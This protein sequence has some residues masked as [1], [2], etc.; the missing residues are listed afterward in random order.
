M[1]LVTTAASHYSPRGINGPPG[2]SLCGCALSGLPPHLVAPVSAPAQDALRVLPATGTPSRPG[3][4]V[5]Q[6]RGCSRDVAGYS[7]R[8]V[9]RKQPGVFPEASLPYPGYHHTFVAPASVSATGVPGGGCALSG[10]PPR[11][12]SPGKRQRHRGSGCALSGLPPRLRSPGK[13]Q[14]HRGFP[15]GVVALSGLPPHL[16]SPGK[17]Q[18]HRG[19][20]GGVV[21]LSG[22][23]PHLR[24]PGKRQ[25]HRGSRM[26]LR[27]IRA[28]TTPS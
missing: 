16:R 17:R 27:L 4:R 6:P 22:L 24:S 10:L 14:R 13:R 7:R 20:P 12:R 28:T 5:R 18:R 3:N 25:R 23:P 9:Q 11:L 21:A 26:R 15:G 1:L 19:V 2:C 8:F